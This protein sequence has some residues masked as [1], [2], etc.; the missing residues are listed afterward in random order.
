MPLRLENLLILTCCLE[1]LLILTRSFQQREA[2]NNASK[3]CS[4]LHVDA[5]PAKKHYPSTSPTA[6]PSVQ[7]AQH[8][9]PTRKHSPTFSYLPPVLLAQK[10][11]VH[12]INILLPSPTF[13][14]LLE[15]SGRFPSYKTWMRERVRVRKTSHRFLKNKKEKK[16]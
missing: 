11:P 6:P 4:F 3:K 7:S 10:L 12:F 5:H 15:D 8:C 13:P 9:L 14:Y 2:S 1:N 16:V